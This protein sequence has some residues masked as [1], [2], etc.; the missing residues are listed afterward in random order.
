MIVVKSWKS[1]YM[2]YQLKVF[3]V[4]TIQPMA[5]LNVVDYDNRRVDKQW[6]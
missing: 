1:V 2:I 5:N 3:Y 6:W 4:Y